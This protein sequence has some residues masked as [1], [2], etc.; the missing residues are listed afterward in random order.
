MH[1]RV[2]S[3][4]NMREVFREILQGDTGGSLSL[5][6]IENTIGYKLRTSLV[7]MQTYPKIKS[8]S[9]RHRTYD[10]ICKLS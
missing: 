2:S 8:T 6:R 1:R 10:N 4:V 5:W 3:L 7:A 9:G